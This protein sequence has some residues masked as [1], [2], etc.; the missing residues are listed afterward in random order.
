[1]IPT[2]YTERLILQPISLDDAAQVQAIFPQWEIVRYLTDQVPW[3]YPP[4]GALSFYR[5]IAIPAMQRGDAWHWTVRL[6]TD[7]GRIIGSVDLT[8]RAT[9][10]TRAETAIAASG[11]IRLSRGKDSCSKP[12]TVLP[13]SDSTCSNCRCCACPRPST[14][15]ARAASLRNRACAW[16]PSRIAITSPATC[17]QKSGRSPA[18]SGRSER[19]S[20]SP[21][22]I[23]RRGAAP[24][25]HSSQL[26]AICCGG[27]TYRPIQ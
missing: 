6:K 11:S 10:L 21:G 23:D 7:P 8:R 13:T 22:E 9:G 18:K 1:M 14:T 16:S 19:K 5:D 20:N 15:P 27:V 4:D 17:L 26:F 2:L 25:R 3:P 12:P 24:T